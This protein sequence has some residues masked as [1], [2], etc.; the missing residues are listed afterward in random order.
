MNIRNYTFEEFVNRVKEFHGY[1]APGIII[2][3]FMVDLAYRQLPEGRL[4][5]ALS[6]TPK[7]LPDAIQLLTPCTVGNGWLTVVNVGRFALT[8][9]DKDSGEGVRVFVDTD[10]LEPWTELKTWFF[11]LKPK[12]EQDTTLLLSQIKEAGSGICGM[13]KVMVAGRFI[14]RRPRGGLAV[15]PNCRE[16]YPLDDGPLCLACSGKENLFVLNNRFSSNQ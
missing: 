13:E 6:E 1:P 15:C 9:Y 4:L 12:K 3:G 5:D 16:G 7:C 11:K 10:K 14:K 2:G 8:L